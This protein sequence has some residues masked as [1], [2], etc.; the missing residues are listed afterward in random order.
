MGFQRVE[1]EAGFVEIGGADAEAVAEGGAD[2]GHATHVVG[3]FLDGD[4]GIHA[5]Q[6]LERRRDEKLGVLDNL[7]KGR[8][9]PV[10]MMDALASSIP[11]KLWLKGF[12]EDK[13]GVK[14]AG[15]AG[16]HDEVAEVDLLG[17]LGDRVDQKIAA[18]RHRVPLDV[19]YS[20]CHQDPT[21]ARIAPGP[22]ACLPWPSALAPTRIPILPR[23]LLSRS[24]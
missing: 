23:C 6:L 1:R 12:I 9:G 10:K 14:I 24:S 18:P 8:A 3:G 17:H 4:E 16:S 22:S 15:S 5:G 11:T 19:N 2:V 13:T 7:R 21:S 20:S